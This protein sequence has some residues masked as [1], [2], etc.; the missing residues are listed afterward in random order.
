M[1]KSEMNFDAIIIGGGLIG[2]LQALSLAQFDVRCAIIEQSDILDMQSD[3]FDGRTSAITSASMNILNLL[4]LDRSILGQGANIKKIIVRDG[5]NGPPLTFDDGEIL[6][7]VFEN[8]KL[9]KALLDAVI[10]HDNIASYFAAHIIDQNIDDYGVNIILDDSTNLRASL[11]IGADGRSSKVRQ[12]AKIT[13]SQWQYDHIALVGAV[14]HDKPHHNIAHELFFNEGP[15]ALLPMTSVSNTQ[16]RSSLIWSIPQS[17]SQAYQ[18]LSPKIFS[19]ELNKKTNGLLGE[20][21]LIAP[22]IT[23]PLGFHSVVQ[24]TAKRVALIGD[25]AHSVH[26]IAGQGL[27]LGF[28]DVAALTETLVDGVRLGLECGDAQLLARY[29]R[30]RSVDTLAVSI[31]TD[32]INHLFALKG[33]TAKSMRRIGM[34]MIDKSDNI[35]TLL[36]R[37]A[38]GVVGGTPKMLSATNL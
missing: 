24:T 16:Y 9:R 34:T 13:L 12:S 19:H 38:R 29:E 26:P 10:K 28:R 25:S 2:L 1:N 20:A 35:K 15:L 37:E 5:N 6:A 17:Q 8:Q 36:S 11:L 18:K 7:T 22:L 27:N 3:N 4:S 30:W 31:A 33:K 23:Y 14:A 32:R 21:N